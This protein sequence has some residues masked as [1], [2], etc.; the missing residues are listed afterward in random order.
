M[1]SKLVP[2]C[3]QSSIAPTPT[4]SHSPPIEGRVF[5]TVEL[6]SRLFLDSHH[7]R[8]SVE[9]YTNTMT[10]SGKIPGSTLTE[11]L[12]DKVS[13][14]LL[15]IFVSVKFVS[16]KRAFVFVNWSKTLFAHAPGVLRMSKTGKLKS[17]AF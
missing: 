14:N 15:Y 5:Q 16:V 3:H 12:T 17:E 1:S 10:S 2:A 11:P 7:N 13:S 9:A 6:L 4:F 8:T